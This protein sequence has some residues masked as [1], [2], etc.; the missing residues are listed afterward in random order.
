VAVFDFAAFAKQGVGFV[1]EWDGSPFSAASTSGAVLSAS[2]VFADDRGEI[3]AIQIQME[4]AA[5]LAAMVLPVPLS[6]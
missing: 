4:I 6:P 2:N 3:D 1:E 5:L